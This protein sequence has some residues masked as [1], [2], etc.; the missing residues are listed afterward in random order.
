MI[1][2]PVPGDRLVA[3]HD[4]TVVFADEVASGDQVHVAEWVWWS[5]SSGTVTSYFAK[6]PCPGC[7]ARVQ[8]RGDDIAHPVEGQGA[9]VVERPAGVET[10]DVAVVCRCGA[11]HGKDGATGC[12]RRWSIRGPKVAGDPG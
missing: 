1:E 6:G 5:Q 8:G 2:H 10:F 4:L 9:T 7:S 3:V 11:S 12:G